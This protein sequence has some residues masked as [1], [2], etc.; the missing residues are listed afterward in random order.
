MIETEDVGAPAERRIGLLRALGSVGGVLAL[1]GLAVMIA[2]GHGELVALESL[3][4]FGLFSAFFTVVVWLVAPGQPANPVVWTMAAS[5]FFGG[6]WLAGLAVAAGIVGDPTLLV[7][8]NSVVPA[9]IPPAAA[10]ILLVTYPSLLLSLFG[11]L[12]F[13]L[14]LFPD[15]RLPS[16]RWRWVGWSAGA[17]VVTLT[18][19]F[20]WG[21]RPWS[22]VAADSGA[23][24]EVG[25]VAV[26]LLIILSFLALALRYRRS[27][28]R[29]R[30][31]FK[32]VVWG[33][34][35]FVPTQI[36]AFTFGGTRYEDLVLIPFLLGTL[37]F[38]A[39]YGIAVG[40]YRLFDIDIVINRTVMVAV[41]GAAIGAIYAGIVVGVGSFLGD[42]TKVGIQVAATAVVAVAF[43]PAR[44]VAQ[45]WANRAVY[46]ERAT[47]YEVLARFSHRAAE[48]SDDELLARIPRLI[49]DG[50]GAAEA[51]LWVAS[52]KGFRSAARWPEESDRREIDG[53]GLFEDPAADYSVPVTHD[54]EHLGG[55]SLVKARGEQLAPSAERLVA[56]LASG[57]GLALRNARLT[58]RLREQVVELEASRERVLVAADE[59]RRALEHDLDSGPQQQ[60][61]AM[62]VM[63][64]PTRKQA[65]QAGAT[66]TAAVL[67]QLEADAGDAIRAVREFSGGVYPPLLEAEGLEVAVAQQA[68]KSALPIDV[69]AAGVGRYP[70]E[71]E[72]AVYFTV[73]EALQNIAKYAEASAVS[74]N[75]R[76][77][78]G[79]LRFDVTDDGIGFDPSAVAAGNG[80]ANMADRLDAVGGTFSVSSVPGAGTIVRGTVSTAAG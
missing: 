7:G 31:Q 66:K 57:L 34:S 16:R 36:A 35:V 44:R 54:G 46:G 38:L 63:L 21:F 1:A 25:F 27:T 20:A 40:R 6:L 9:T 28:G 42:G 23:L 74:V 32:W 78:Q 48:A 24:V 4:V 69:V 55:L 58:G 14:L 45:Q 61:V 76:D 17:G 73:L 33:A 64:G 5:A 47:P 75:L 68:R 71:I 53:A 51:T 59:A 67:A 62:K 80:L 19:A 18:V 39:S 41:L 79:E 70:R 72:A 29:T 30:Q 26:G 11:L 37:A 15:G 8:G 77:A 3:W 43:G 10:W 65:V 56:N 52:G 60:L 2:R 49:V 22:T 50:T 12:T 13:G